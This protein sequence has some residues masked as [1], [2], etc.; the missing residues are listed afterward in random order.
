VWIYATVGT[1]HTT[2]GFVSDRTYKDAGRSGTGY[3]DHSWTYDFATFQ[4]DSG[5]A[6]STVVR[7]TL[8]TDS[9][10]A[11][12]VSSSSGNQTT[13]SF[14]NTW[15]GTSGRDQI[16][17][18]EHTR[19]DPAVSTTKNGSGSSNVWKEYFNQN[20]TLAFENTPL[21][22][23]TFH[24]YTNGQQTKLIEDADTT[25]NGTGQDFSGVTVPG[26]F[27][28][29]SGVTA[30]HRVTTWTYDA[31]GRLDTATADTYTPKNWYTRLKDHRGVVLHFTH[32]VS[33]SPTTYYGPVA[34]SVHNQTGFTEASGTIGLS[35][36][37]T[38]SAPS[39]FVDNTS[40]DV[41]AAI[42][43]GTL[44]QLS[45]VVPT[46]VGTLVA[47]SRLYTTIP[48]TMPG[49]S[50]T[51]YDATTYAFDDLE[52]TIRTVV[53]CGTI[54]R[55]V[56]DVLGRVVEHWVGTDDTGLA[57]SPM[58]GTSNMTKTDAYEYD[59][60]N[61][62]GNG[63]VTKTTQYVENSTTNQRETTF[64]NDAFGRAVLVTTPAAP[65]VLNKFDGAGRLV[66]SGLYTSTSGLSA[67]SDPTSVTSNRV[68]LRETKYDEISNVW[69]T[70]LHKIDPS[71]GSDDDTLNSDIWRDANGRSVKQQ[72]ENFTKVAY[73]RV[74]R[75]TRVYTLASSDDT[76][77][78][79]AMD[80]SGDIVLEEHD[81]TYDASEGSVVL[82]TSIERN[83]ADTTANGH[84]PTTG[85]LYTG[86]DPLKVQVAYLHGRAQITA[87][88]NGLQ[89]VTDVV[90]YGTNSD[91]DFDRT[92]LT[93]PSRSTSVKRT[94]YAYNDDGTVY[95]VQDPSVAASRMVKLVHD[96]AGRV[97]KQI[98]NWDGT[99]GATPTNP[100]V[101]VTKEFT[102][103]NGLLTSMTRR[104]PSGQSSQTTTYAYGTS[105]GTSAGDS[106][107]ATGHL[108]QSI[109]Y[110]DSTSSGDV[111]KYAYDARGALIWQKEPEPSGTTAN[112]IQY[113]YDPLGRNTQIRAT[114]INTST[115][116]YVKRIERAYDNAGRL[117]FVTQYDNATV[118]SGTVTDQMKYDYDSWGNIANFYQDV[119]S[120]IG[121]SGSLD[122]YR[123]T[124][125]Y[126][127]ASS[128]GRHTLRITSMALSVYDTSAYSTYDTINYTYSSTD[129]YDDAASR[130]TKVKDG[131]TVMARYDYLGVDSIVGD[132][133]P[134]PGIHAH[135]YN[136]STNAYDNLDPFNQPANDRWTKENTTPVDFV[137]KSYTWDENSNLT[138]VTD[139]VHHGFDVK[140]TRDH[141]DRPTEEK[142]GTLS[143]SPP[144]ISSTK[145]DQAW[146]RDHVT[147]T[148]DSLDM[149]GDGVY[150]GTNEYDDART[151]DSANN[152]AG[153]DLDSDPSTTTN[154]LTLTYDNAHR[155]VDD[156]QNYKYQYDAFGR[157]R[158]VTNRL[159]LALVE[160]RTY[161]GLNNII[162][163][164]YDNNSSSDDSVPDGSVDSTY[165]KWF[166]M[167]L[168]AEGTRVAQFRASDTTPKQVITSCPQGVRPH[169]PRGGSYHA[170]SSDGE[171]PPPP[172]GN[173][174][175]PPGFKSWFDF[176]QWERTQWFIFNHDIFTPAPQPRRRHGNRAVYEKHDSALWA[177]AATS[178]NKTIHVCCDAE[179]SV[180]ALVDDSGR[181]IEGRCYTSLGIPI[182]IPAGDVNSDSNCDQAD[183]TA[184]DNWGSSPYD[185]RADVNLDGVVDPSDA[186]LVAGSFYSGGEGARFESGVESGFHGATINVAAAT[187]TWLI[188]ACNEYISQIDTLLAPQG[189]AAPRV[190]SGIRATVAA[191]TWLVRAGAECMA[192]FLGAAPQQVSGGAP[193]VHPK[194]TSGPDGVPTI[195]M[196]PNTDVD[197]SPESPLRDLERGMTA[198]GKFVLDDFN[199]AKYARFREN[200][201]I[202]S[203]PYSGF[204]W[205]HPDFD[206]VKGFHVHT[207]ANDFA[208]RV[209]TEIGFVT[210]AKTPHSFPLTR[211][212]YNLISKTKNWRLLGKAVVGAEVAMTG[213]EFYEAP[214][215]QARIDVVGRAATSGGCAIAGGYIGGAISGLCPPLLPFAP[216]LV[217]GG[218][219]T[220][221]YV[222]DVAY[223]WV[224]AQSSRLASWVSNAWNSVGSWASSTWNSVGSR[225][226]DQIGTAVDD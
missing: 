123:T 226:G 191:L 97:V 166:H 177:S 11:A 32:S 122:D 163:I 106:K 83:H 183:L 148:H 185:V 142:N 108:L 144:A 77:Y 137:S 192:A 194:L 225:V 68:A 49:S 184:I 53:P 27:T 3:Y 215:A 58:S 45:T 124:Y 1:G 21:G 193:Q 8:A 43:V 67:T 217:A 24:Q 107:I 210:L 7:P 150:T 174:P 158:K 20:G 153:R 167:A 188:G 212:A 37:S 213:Y 86:T 84:T 46:S 224:A 75:V 41:L 26:D 133:R 151:Y 140:F 117:Q 18:A 116:G 81:T 13:T 93:V 204:R 38:T 145:R 71:D 16:S 201:R 64:T 52:R 139:H 172:L 111:H 141:L 14:S 147:L 198:G 73:D 102:L 31:Q 160:E 19:T 59:S 120:A 186:A 2:K 189:D 35:G 114:T 4:V 42:Q 190:L 134:G 206:P 119:N 25:R 180:I 62:K 131:S 33:G 146:T 178:L 181:F 135:L 80:L 39:A 63:Y 203:S 130:V 40:D 126:A 90:E 159:T 65:Y 61:D 29:A 79:N 85:A 129:K 179:G 69:R 94:S 223:P 165:D 51:N 48:S 216:A 60:T 103:T 152:L 161:D 175:P 98:A 23:V 5:D 127:K 15:Y 92:S 72:G 196:V 76:N 125:S 208:I 115:D 57:G 121:A 109:A 195:V 214:N 88:W 36:N 47:E 101:N 82:T 55:P 112:V 10:Y 136:D 34:Y 28:T 156:G 12:K 173:E 100:D 89:G 162:G 170:P 105:R 87:Y 168:D 113:D 138:S 220:G 207:F 96:A 143:G 211:S 91:A 202:V 187:T 104:L 118:G 128:S 149:N 56:Y 164:H 176:Y 44:R 30:L 78:S 209:P 50:G 74:D 132:N 171:V 197:W 95:T 6:A 222:G 157:K 155:L 22:Y 169:R 99:S 17:L 221:G 54:E 154:N 70:T 110:P 182:V 9:Y 199:W 200:V 218:S 205:F 219:I 66:A